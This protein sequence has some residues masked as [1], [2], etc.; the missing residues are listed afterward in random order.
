[1]D[2]NI[3]KTLE[4]GLESKSPEIQKATSTIV[5]TLNT[6]LLPLAILNEGRKKVE[7]YFKKDFKRELEEKIDKIPIENQ[8]EPKHNIARQAL[9]GISDTLD[10]PALKDAF[11]NT[12]A[13]SFDD[14]QDDSLFLAYLD[15]IQQL[16]SQG[17]SFFIKFAAKY[18]NANLPHYP[19]IYFSE[20][21]QI[22]FSYSAVKTDILEIPKR[23]MIDNWVRLGLVT[24]SPQFITKAPILVDN[25]FV[26][27]KTLKKALEPPE[28]SLTIFDIRLTDF[29]LEFL[30]TVDEN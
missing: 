19:P 21:N 13:K 22:D 24:L 9:S 23:A 16:G 4:K 28:M 18:Q 20:K 6:V 14:R 17:L 5:D 3:I 12:L 15:T 30:Q 26:M 10:Q 29:A 25:S 1:M 11:L 7:T 27:G 8:Q 2:N